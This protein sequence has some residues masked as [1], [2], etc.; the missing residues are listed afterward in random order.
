MSPDGGHIISYTFELLL[1]MEINLAVKSWIPT[2]IRRLAV[3]I[4]LH[5][6]IWSSSL[7]SST[8]QPGWLDLQYLSLALQRPCKFDFKTRYNWQPLEVWNHSKGSLH[9]PGMT[10]S[11]RTINENYRVSTFPW[12]GD[13]KGTWTAKNLHQQSSALENL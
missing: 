6:L 1:R 2:A 11:C 3:V 13:R 4:T 7:P 9:H 8:I 10:I 5:L 12:L